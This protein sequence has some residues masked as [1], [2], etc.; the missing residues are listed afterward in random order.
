[1]SDGAGKTNCVVLL[2]GFVVLAG[3]SSD[4]SASIPARSVTTASP[5]STHVANDTEQPAALIRRLRRPIRIATRGEGACRPTLGRRFGELKAPVG[6]RRAI[7]PG[8]GPAY[9][10]LYS[11]HVTGYRPDR[12]GPGRY[13]DFPEQGQRTLRE[14]KVLWAVEPGHPGAV[15]IR[16]RSID[17]RAPI[18]FGSAQ[19]PKEELLLPEIEGQRGWRDHP[20]YMMVS[21]P[22]CYAFQI[23][24]GT[25]SS[26]VEFELRAES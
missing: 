15:L 2:C 10:N 21:R 9:P 6:G 14:I 8:E 24:A 7:A 4:R 23:D 5:P 18:R 26:V 25:G 3:C 11:A 16:G 22:G 19:A 20:S 12:A 17:G 1:M 13:V